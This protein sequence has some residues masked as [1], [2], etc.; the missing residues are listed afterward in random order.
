MGLFAIYLFS[1]I[2]KE[3][4]KVYRKASKRVEVSFSQV[5][6]K[7]K[8][9]IMQEI[10]NDRYMDNSPDVSKPPAEVP[11]TFPNDQT[12]EADAGQPDLK[13]NSPAPPEQPAESLDL[14]NQIWNGADID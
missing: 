12:A 5:P 2:N 10:Y 1:R 11:D 3:H 14:L 13:P 8:Q 4:L 9:Q 6:D 7:T